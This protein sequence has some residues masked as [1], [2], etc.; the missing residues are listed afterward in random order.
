MVID[1]IV[2]SISNGITVSVGLL[3]SVGSALLSIIQALPCWSLNRDSLPTLRY[4][5]NR[6]CVHVIFYF[7]NGYKFLFSTASYSTILRCFNTYPLVLNL[8]PF[9]LFYNQVNNLLC[10]LCVFSVF[11]KCV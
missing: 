2:L 6:K 3:P 1:E 4:L 7:G 9:H 5:S 8:S 11:L 10:N